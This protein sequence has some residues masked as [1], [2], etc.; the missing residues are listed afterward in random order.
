MVNRNYY[1]GDRLFHSKD[2]IGNSRYY[3]HDRNGNIRSVTNAANA[4]LNIYSYTPYGEDISSLCVETVDNSWKFTG[5]YYDAEIG[6]YYLRARQYSPYLARFNGYDPVLGSFKEPFTLH[7]YL[8]CLNDPMNRIDPTG[9]FS[10]NEQISVQGIGNAIN[11]GSG[12]YDTANMI[13]DMAQQLND[14]MKLRAVMTNVAMESMKNAAGN[15]IFGAA[16]KSLGYVAKGIY[17]LS[18][19]GGHHGFP[20]WLGGKVKQWLYKTPYGKGT[21]HFD[22]E[23]K[24]KKMMKEKF[25]IQIGGREGSYSKFAQKLRDN[26]G[27][28]MEVF[29]ELSYTAADFD[30]DNGTDFAEA[31]LLNFTEEN[32][33]VIK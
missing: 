23:Q 24:V 17:K 16:M 12:A 19:R 27:M 22:F 5:Q 28:Q 18:K 14:G 25:D 8:Y 13:K 15:R 32:F 4:L 9:E 33:D 11:F 7:Q 1:Y 30:L 3:F 6:Q 31:L 20:M 29:E 2:D 26:P 10:L 21:K